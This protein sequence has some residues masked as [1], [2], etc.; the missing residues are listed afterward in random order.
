[1][2]SSGP[3]PPPTQA[4]LTR[5]AAP[6]PVKTDAIGKQWPA[7]T[8]EVGLEK[9]R[10]YANA[11]GASNPVHHD[12]ETAKSAGFR[13]VVAP[14]TVTRDPAASV[15][16]SAHRKIFFIRLLSRRGSGRAV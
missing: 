6:M 14:P 13:D 4:T 15:T 10:E 2:V 3:I 11:I 1:M 12:R 5:I 7:T 8:Y 9:I 16:A